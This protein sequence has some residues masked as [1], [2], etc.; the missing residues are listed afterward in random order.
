M[1]SDADC[2]EPRNFVDNHSFSSLLEFS[3]FSFRLFS[4]DLLKLFQFY[5]AYK[6]KINLITIQPISHQTNQKIKIDGII[7][8]D[9]SNRPIKGNRFTNQL[10]HSYRIN[11][12]KKI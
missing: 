8:P 5:T 11:K 12:T 9:T 2:S 7:T 4:R 1:E 3:I 6:I 10:N